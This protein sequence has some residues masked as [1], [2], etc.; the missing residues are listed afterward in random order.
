MP[1]NPATGSTRHNKNIMIQ[2]QPVDSDT[3]AFH[4]TMGYLHCLFDYLRQHHFDLQPVLNALGLE[5]DDI[6]DR[7]RL[8][9]S[10]ALD[11]AFDAAAA[12]T[13]DPLLGFRVGT[14]MRSTHLGI[15]GYLTLCCDNPRDLLQLHARYGQLVGNGNRP[16]Y[17]ITD[18]TIV[19]H[20]RFPEG[21]PPYPRQVVDFSLTGW[22]TIGRWLGGPDFKPDFVETSHP[23][24][25]DYGPMREYLGC[26]IRFD[27]PEI[28]VSLPRRFLDQALMHGDTSLRPVLE[29]E[30]RRRMQLVHS[31]QQQLDPLLARIRQLV[32]DRLM[33]GAPELQTVADA[34]NESVRSLQRHLES[35]HTSYK[36]LL[37]EVRQ[38]MAGQH[39]RDHHLSLVD[40]A[41]MLGFSDQSTFQRAFKRWFGV[42]PGEYRKTL[43][44]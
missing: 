18:D 5:A 40:V 11:M 36:Q 3:P 34:A 6:N 43:G 9:P 28:R 21:R 37:D 15:V 1:Q 24:A 39:L 8:L 13:G 26:D 14:Q 35:R 44:A 31:R 33:L 22:L 12:L 29:A 17:T 7:D 25:A 10:T 23:E 38:E 20:L 27:C 16:E 32:A 4:V 2:F 42:S 30:V 19:M 41:L